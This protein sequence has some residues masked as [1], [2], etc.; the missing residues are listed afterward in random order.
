WPCTLQTPANFNYFSPAPIAGE[1]FQVTDLSGNLVYP[2]QGNPAPAQAV[3]P[4]DFNTL[5]VQPITFPGSS[6]QI[7]L[8]DGQYFLQWSA[9]DNVGILEQNVQFV[10]SGTCPNPAGGTFPVPCYQTA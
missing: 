8:P 9:V 4:S 6:N 2:A 10:S 7:S 1:T 5:T 3:P